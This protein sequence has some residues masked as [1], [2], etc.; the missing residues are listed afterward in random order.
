[1][2]LCTLRRPTHSVLT[3]CFFIVILR[4]YQMSGTCG[5]RRGV[6]RQTVILK[7]SF[8]PGTRNSVVA[9]IPRRLAGSDILNTTVTITRVFFFVLVFRL[10]PTLR[11]YT[12]GAVSLLNNPPCAD[13]LF[14]N[15]DLL[16]IQY[17]CSAK[18]LP[19]SKQRNII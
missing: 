15:R 7:Y 11:F 1:M 12:R 2:E 13:D 17:E 18:S 9:P 10:G 6:C 14:F 16:R 4:G 5:G 3:R 8:R 19:G